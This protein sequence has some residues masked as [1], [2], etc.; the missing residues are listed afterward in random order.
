VA[1]SAVIYRPYAADRAVSAFEGGTLH[2]NNDVPP[3]RIGALREELTDRLHLAPYLGSF[4]FVFGDGDGPLADLRVRRALAMAAD[5]DAIAADIWSG[6]MLP[7]TS[8]VPRG[9][10]GYGEPA[11]FDH[12]PAGPDERRA[13]AAALLAEAGIGPERPLTL[14]IRIPASE[15]NRRTAAALIAGWG[16]LG[17]HATVIEA[18]AGEHYRALAEARDYDLASVAWIGDYNDASTFLELFRSGNEATNFA[19]YQNPAYDGFLEEAANTQD[20]EVRSALLF[21]ADRE[22]MGDLPVLPLLQYGSLN[23]VS[24]LLVGWEDNVLDIHPSRWLSLA[25]PPAAEDD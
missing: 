4:F 14:R 16:P 11:E 25:E 7:S 22:L 21:R 20:R 1:L 5:R 13:A 3:F 19:R 8:L 6:A 10:A 9:I 17:V 12:G 15:L 18:E 24:P 2:S 23:L